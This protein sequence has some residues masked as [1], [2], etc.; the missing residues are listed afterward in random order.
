L[1]ARV[2]HFYGTDARLRVLRN[3]RW[4]PAKWLELHRLYQ[5]G[6]EL[7]IERV[8]VTVIAAEPGAAP[9]SVEEEYLVVL[10][11]HLLNTGTFA[12]TE[13]DWVG[14]R[15]RGWCRGLEL[16]RTLRAVEGLCVDLAGKTGFVHCDGPADGETCR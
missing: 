1:L 4:I 16:E 9:G 14:A 13:I 8:P 6:L 5:Q 7:G 2:I 15:L 10:L 12:P 11:T 3:E